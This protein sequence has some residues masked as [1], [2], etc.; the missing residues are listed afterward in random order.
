MTEKKYKKSK[1]FLKGNLTPANTVW[2]TGYNIDFFFTTPHF[3]FHNNK[4]L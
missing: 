1:P 4:L 2:E 3:L